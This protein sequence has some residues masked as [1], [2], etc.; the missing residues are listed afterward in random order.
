ML[1]FCFHYNVLKGKQFPISNQ[2][3]LCEDKSDMLN[4]IL[5]AHSPIRR[6][7]AF[8]SRHFNITVSPKL[9]NNFSQPTPDGIEQLRDLIMRKYLPSWYSGTDLDGHFDSEEWWRIDLEN[10][11][12]RRLEMDRYRFVPWIDRVAPFKKNPTIL[13]V[14]CGTGS[15]AVAMAE[16]GADVVAIDAHLEAIEVSRPRAQIHGLSNVSFIYGNAQNLWE[17]VGKRRFDLIVFFAVLEHMTL[18]ECK[19][20]LRA[21]WEILPKGKHICITD[22]P[23]RL[24]FYDA[25]T[26]HLPFFNWLPDELAFEYSKRSSRYP[27]NMRF[28]ELNNDSMVLF[29]RE[30]RGVSF[31]EIDLAL[32]DNCKYK[33]I[34]DLTGF[35]SLRN[36]AM[37]LKRFLVG[38]GRRE[39]LLNSYAPDRHRSFFRES[40]D[41]VIEK[42]D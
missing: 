35:L 15:A 36:P 29:I 3:P 6:K 37:T 11:L 4:K 5:H 31:H 18:K 20:S 39:K 40:L 32:D 10:H 34:S 28:R 9:R 8:L 22:T 13:E 2:F 16:Q 21:A 30:G 17:L 7:L 12:F 25:H 24:W 42:L 26:S 19:S 38:A 1:H 33:I 23:N 41:L 27:F 14:G